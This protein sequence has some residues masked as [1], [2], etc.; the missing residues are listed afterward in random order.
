MKEGSMGWRSVLQAADG[1]VS[2]LKAKWRM[3]WNR[4]YWQLRSW[5]IADCSSWAWEFGRP[6]NAVFT[7]LIN[8]IVAI[9]ERIVLILD[10]YHLI[11]AQSIHDAVTVLLR[12]LPPQ[13]H[14]V[15]ATRDD[16]HLPLAHLRA[17]RQSTELRA[18]AQC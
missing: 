7:S 10:D 1:M 2:K 4:L 3:R 5:L 17:R 8:E 12:H 14:L 18:V 11:D 15:I 13:M 6:L 9:P 16:S